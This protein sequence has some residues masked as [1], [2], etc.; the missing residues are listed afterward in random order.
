MTYRYAAMR[1]K[2]SME[3][4]KKGRL[5]P[6]CIKKR[7]VNYTISCSS[8]PLGV[9]TNNVPCVYFSSCWL[10]SRPS[11]SSSS[12][13][14]RGTMKLTNLKISQDTA[15]LYHTAQAI[16]FSWIKKKEGLPYNKPLAPPV[17]LTVS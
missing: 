4:T 9:A 7:F 8:S 2:D 6:A 12:L 5:T 11:S 1:G 17:L 13:T 16:A 14:R 3:K 15:K 10:A